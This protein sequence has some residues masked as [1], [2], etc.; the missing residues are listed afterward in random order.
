MFWKKENPIVSSSPAGEGG[1][2]ILAEEA[3]YISRKLGRWGLSF[4]VK[5]SILFDTFS[6]SEEVLGE[7]EKSRVDLKNIKDIVISH[8]HWDHTG[9]LSDILTKTSAKL[10]LPYD[11]ENS[12]TGDVVFSKE[13]LEIEKGVYLSGCIDFEYKGVKMSEQALYLADSKTLITGCA[14]P[15][16]EK[17]IKVV[18][19]NIGEV[20]TVIGGFHWN[21]FSSDEIE[22]RAL[23][24]KNDYG[25]ERVGACHCSGETAEKIFKTLYRD[26]AIEVREGVVIN[27]DYFRF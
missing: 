11:M 23:S 16:V 18:S 5:G 4:L 22:R 25:I 13:S 3:A 19:S 26:N 7:L 17:I 24:L 9:G 15:S 10:Y 14:H 2:I 8:N 21:S 20:K 27:L 1:L 12:Y 6:R